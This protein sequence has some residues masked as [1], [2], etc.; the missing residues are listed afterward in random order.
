MATPRRYYDFHEKEYI[1]RIGAG[2]SGWDA[3]AYD[4]FFMR[5]FVA[6]SLDRTQFRPGA[7]ALDLG[8][9]TGALSCQLAEAGLDVTGV[10][11]SPTAIALARRMAAERQLRI[12]FEIGDVLH[13]MDA[14]HRFDLVVDGHLLHCI[15]FAEERRELLER[16][17]AALDAG[18][19]FWVETMCLDGTTPPN[20]AWNLDERGVVWMRVGDVD[21]CAGAVQRDGLWWLPQRLIACSPEVLLDELRSAG[22]V[23]VESEF[24]GP[25][26]ANA[27]GGL[28]ARC[29]CG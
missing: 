8:C 16:V 25:L 13:Y 18:G 9:G 26:E 4:A 10:D 24:Y 29:T 12:N 19:E 5:P 11:L 28:R 22:L 21:G 15:V 17:R 14:P 23:I 7:R 3:G 2:Q 27:P 1:R 6:R 20:A